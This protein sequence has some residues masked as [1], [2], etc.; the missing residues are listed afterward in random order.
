MDIEKKSK[1]YILE[2]K[3]KYSKENINKQLK[4]IGV[5]EE[6]INNCWDEIEDKANKL[7]IEEKNITLPNDLKTIIGFMFF[8]GFILI[9]L[10]ILNP[11]LYMIL[12]LGIPAIS[13]FILAFG[14]IKLSKIA[15][16]LSILLFSLSF[17]IELILLFLNKVDFS[18]DYIIRNLI[19]LS[20]IFYLLKRKVKNL[21]EENSNI[22]FKKE[23]EK[24]IFNYNKEKLK[25]SSYL[26]IFLSLIVFIFFSVNSSIISGI[27]FI[28]IALPFNVIL[29]YIIICIYLFYKRKNLK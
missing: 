22:D 24:E 29:S 16:I 8:I 19:V 10:V 13:Y 3:D 11:T 9:I 20:I 27:L 12:L 21:F 5:S 14:L 7:N 28:V 25:Y 18:F 17:F 4:E 2:N 1:E 26:V 15:R 23:N 6:V